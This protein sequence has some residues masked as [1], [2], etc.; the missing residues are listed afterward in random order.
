MRK[1]W[2]KM[3]L[4]V[5]L[6]YRHYASQ[7]RQLENLLFFVRNGKTLHEG[8]NIVKLLEIDGVKFVVKSFVRISTFNRILY[9]SLRKSKAM[10]S[11]LHAIRLRRL[12]IDTPEE[13]AVAEVRRRGMMRY[14][15]YIS[16]YSD[17]APLSPVT[18]RYMRSDE[19]KAVLDALVQFLA[20]M[21]WAGVLHRD[22]NVGNILWKQ[23]ATD[24]GAQYAF[25]IIDIN[26][27]SFK[28]T[29][30]MRQRLNNLRRLSCGASAYLY[31][32]QQYAAEIDR[33]SD[34][35]QLKGVFR[36]LL[37]EQR[38][39]AKRKVKSYI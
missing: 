26:R 25:Q 14:C 1:D 37:F 19:A 3:K 5:N 31:I 13:V 18:E 21:H 10:R 12:G 16:R 15:Y 7:F 22:L 23:T 8:R 11:Y 35:V 28:T 9:G 34:T 32:L 24:G 38:Q 4:I 29:L 20:K 33:N 39:R 30:S 2:P 36:R 27:M 6:K 17:Y